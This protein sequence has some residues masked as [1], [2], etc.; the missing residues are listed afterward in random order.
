M[1]DT[2]NMETLTSDRPPS[3]KEF[4]YGNERSSIKSNDTGLP[5]RGFTSF[6]SQTQADKSMG[7]LDEETVVIVLKVC[8]APHQYLI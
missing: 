3:L 7:T 2:S 4:L 5:Q 8:Y 6:A 1:V